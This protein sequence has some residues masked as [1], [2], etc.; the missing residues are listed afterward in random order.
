VAE[1]SLVRVAAASFVFTTLLLAKPGPAHA[2]DAERVVEAG[3]AYDR[4]AAA[5]NSGQY[6]R[7]AAELARA[8]ALVPNATTLALALRAALRTDDP[9]LGMG[10]VERAEQRPPDEALLAASRAARDRFALRAGRL[11]IVCPPPRECGAEVDGAVVQVGPTFWA[12]LGDHSIELRARADGALEHRTVHVDA[13]ASVEVRPLPR[14]VPPPP[15][16]PA[17]AEPAPRPPVLPGPPA[18]TGLSPAWF[19]IAGGA[20]VVLGGV[21][22]ASAVDTKNRYSAYTANP[23]LDGRSSG[24]AAQLR[25]NVLFGVT[26]A[27]AVATAAVGLFAVRWSA[28]GARG[29]HGGSSAAFVIAGPTVTFAVSY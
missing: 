26:A 21:A 13:G 17:L 23:T 24:E 18:S 5:Y 8:D 2:Q 19:W 1:G 11:T 4:G 25:T 6:A 3:A 29:S 27:A 20:T 16:P 10:L 28:N 14:A 15:S 12:T 7:A 9:V 22:A